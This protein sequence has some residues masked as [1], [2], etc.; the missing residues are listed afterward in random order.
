VKKI[1]MAAV[2]VLAGLVGVARAE[3]APALTNVQIIN[4]SSTV[5]GSEPVSTAAATTQLD[6]KGP[7]ITVTVDETG[8]VWGRGVKLDGVAMTLVSQTPLVGTDK[9]VYGRRVV[10]RLTNW[11]TGTGVLVA[12]SRCAIVPLT[13]KS[14]SLIVK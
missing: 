9:L 6:H 5:A 7:T 1:L 12:Q 2:C 3:Q 10:W 13:V 14:D 4:V 11:T 8:T